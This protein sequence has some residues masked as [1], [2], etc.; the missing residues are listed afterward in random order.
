MVRPKTMLSWRQ[1]MVV[2]QVVVKLAVNN[3]FD[4][5]GDDR[6]ERDWPE[7]GG[8]GGVA[9]FVEGMD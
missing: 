4:N 1:E 5:F 8:I 9:G 3:S 7:V 6:D 2:R